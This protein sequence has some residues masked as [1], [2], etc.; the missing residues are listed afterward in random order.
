MACQGGTCGEWLD[1]GDGVNTKVSYYNSYI[2]T[3]L[4][5]EIILLIRENPEPDSIIYIYNL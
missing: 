4:D 3:N 1:I 2:T 5:I